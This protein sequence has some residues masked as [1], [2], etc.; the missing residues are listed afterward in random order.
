[1]LSGDPRLRA[2]LDR[3]TRLQRLTAA[4]GAATT[5]GE[6]AAVVVEEGSTVLGAGAA[7]LVLRD[8]GDPGWLELARGQGLP[9]G[10]NEAWRRFPLDAPAI[11]AAAIR[12]GAPVFVRD[13]LEGLSD[14]F[15]GVATVVAASGFRGWAALPL[16]PAAQPA[17]ALVFAFAE[18]LTVDQEDRA[19]L[20]AFAEQC[21]QAVARAKL[22]EALQESEARFRHMADNAPVVIWVT[23]RDGACTYL[24]ARWT[25]VTGVAESQ[26]LELGWLDAVHPDDRERIAAG[27]KASGTA[28]GPVALEYRL[29]RADGSY[30]W[31]LDSAV[32][33]F[34]A[35]G[36]FLGYIGSVVDISERQA[37]E[38][39]TRRRAGLL[40]QSADA[41]I[42][43]GFEGTIRYWNEGAATL[44]G[45]S[46]EEALGRASHELL[47]TVFPEPLAAI[48][49]RL[50]AEGTWE[51]ELTHARRDGSSLVVESR[52]ALATF[53]EGEQVVLETNR[54]VTVRRERDARLRDVQKMEAVGR[55]AGGVAHESN[56]QMTVVLG[57]TEFVLRRNDLPAAVRAELE[58]IRRAAE[59]TAGI[60]RQLL[61]FGRRQLL[62]LEPLDLG[63]VVR[64]FDGILQR[65]VGA[66]IRLELRLDAAARPVLA[67]RGQVEQ[68][69]VNLVLN[70]RDAMGASGTVTIETAAVRLDAHR[71]ADIPGE[72]IPPG[73]Y[74]MLAVADTGSGIP[75]EVRP[76]L[77]EPFFTT[78]PVGEGTG[79]G[80]A[81]VYG[82]VKQSGGFLEVESVPGSGSVFRIYLPTARR[83]SVLVVEDE[84]T[85]RQLARRTLE[86]AGCDV[87]EAAEGG[88][89]LALLERNGDRVMCVVTDVLMPGVGG[90]ELLRRL[91][92]RRSTLPVVLMSGYADLDELVRDGRVR[93]GIELMVKPFSPDDLAARVGRLLRP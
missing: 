50:R 17:G 12:D 73:A 26:G 86:G 35:G 87:L 77:F 61:A 2:A 27:W 15:S 33:R 76:H 29:R 7:A 45:W 4:L 14:R 92:E 55:L 56:N 90:V 51:G 37:R 46:R 63:A 58:Q 25:A 70:A 42:V 64:G 52:W 81:T 44:Y 89:A 65:S 85:V 69:L 59:R 88:E 13:F 49:S 34:G 74:T 9:P 80:L 22:H 5:L 6:V 53:D 71:R 19:F 48:E 18:P 41:I 16:G 23:D 93:K 43:R 8:P 66:G 75:A 54:D 62:Q 28:H 82:I 67:D 60:T 39:E 84:P 91:E 21:A 24:N 31:V 68:V 32:A 40:E 10:I 38:V 36:E 78:K 79:L 83:P 1:M 20:V 47:R 3:V 11:S 30:A 72:V 57:C